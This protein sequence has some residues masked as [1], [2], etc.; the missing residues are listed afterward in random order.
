MRRQR[1][2]PHASDLPIADMNSWLENGSFTGRSHEHEASTTAPNSPSREPHGSSTSS[3][4]QAES[5]SRSSRPNPYDEDGGRVVTLPDGTRVA[6][7]DGV[8][9]YGPVP[10]P[11]PA[12]AD[13]EPPP[14]AGAEFMPRPPS[15]GAFEVA[16]SVVYAWMQDYE[17]QLDQFKLDSAYDA[18]RGFT[19]VILREMPEDS[20]LRNVKVRQAIN[21]A[22]NLDAIVKNLVRGSSQIIH[23]AC[24]PE[25]FGCTDDVQKYPYDPAKAKA[26]LAEAGYPNGFSTVFYAYRDRPHNEAIMSDLAAVGIKA[27]LRYGQYA[28]TR[29]ALRRGET[30]ITSMTWGSNSIPD[31]DAILPVFFGGLPDDLSNDAEVQA[32][33]LEGKSTLD[34]DKRKAAYK[35]ALQKI[36]EQAYWVPTWTYT[37]NY[38]ISN[39]LDF[40]PTA[41]EIP[42]FWTASWK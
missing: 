42:R 40:K 20:P 11:Q 13:G 10:N 7:P 28:A 1:A 2:N 25:Q 39:D 5:A 36:A 37:T 24:Y 15:G 4:P 19:G 27:E 22:I 29:D 34:Q 16:P 17:G 31:V 23:S 21:H 8:A 38:A 6:L 18:R 41:D 14:G 32:W 30:P 35:K 33:L 26:L 9:E 3:D 12:A